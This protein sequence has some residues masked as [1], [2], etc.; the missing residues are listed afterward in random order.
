MSW[1]TPQDFNE[2][3]QNPSLAFRDSELRGGQPELTPLGLPRPITGGFAS[4]Y[5]LQCPERTWAVRCFLRQYQD[6]ERRYAAIS[7]HLTRSKLPYTV[8]FTFLRDGIKVRGQWYPILK[9]E[10]VHGESL[11]A[12]IEKH[13]GNRNALLS[14]ARNWAEMVKAIQ[15]ASIAHGDL[16]HSNVLVVDGQLR[17]IDY[18]GMYVP[19]LAGEASHEVGHRNY[20][21]PLRTESDFGPYLDNFSAWV[22]YVSLIALAADP[23]LWKRFS[24]GDECLLFRRRDF[25]HPETSDIFRALERHR[26]EEIRSAVAIFKTLLYLR[27][28]DVPSLDGQITPVDASGR[29]A[30]GGH[31]SWLDDHIRPGTAATPVKVTTDNTLGVCIDPSWIVEHVA[32]ESSVTARVSFRNSAVLERLVVAVSAIIALVWTAGMRSLVFVGPAPWLLEYLFLVL[33]NLA[34][35]MCRY[36]SDPSVRELISLKSRLKSIENKLLATQHAIALANREKAR[37]HKHKLAEEKQLGWDLKEYKAKE[38]KEINACRA[39]FHSAFSSINAKRRLLHQQKANDLRKIQNEI[40]VE[41]SRLNA[42][43]AGLP[44]AESADLANRL[45][46]RQ[47]EH[48]AKCLCQFTLESA[49]IEGVGPAFKA[50]LLAYGFH[51]AADVD[52]HAVQRVPGIGPVRARAIVTWRNSLEDFARSTMPSALSPSDVAA[53]RTKYADLRRSLVQLRDQRQSEIKTAEE[54]IESQ[55]RIALSQLQVKDNDAN[56]KA[57]A[58]IGEIQARYA[59]QYCAIRQKLSK[60]ADE[61]ASKCRDLDARIVECRTESFRLHWE[62]EK[63]RRQFI[64]YLGVRFR[65]Y[66]KRIFFVSWST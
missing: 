53:I 16:Q 33:I 52:F 27:P 12:F 29:Q 28:R 47:K 45:R 57:Q 32:P 51:T 6:H 5:K 31:P 36:R 41:V 34:L 62:K 8:G 58:A 56:A 49:S 11:T 40:G 14:L 21:H 59:Q 61:I 54:K 2:V 25:E 26:E 18:D 13:L 46:C 63:L 44:H 38:A 19:A 43:I 65:N 23:K 66:V 30:S 24:G 17:L 39:A 50:R 35:W 20:Q 3:V 64:P 48:V 9:M 4:V 1:P 37:L 60:L 22:V 42:K 15:Q 10:W 7:D 55:Y